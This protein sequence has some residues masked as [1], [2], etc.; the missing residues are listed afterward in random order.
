MF[1]TTGANGGGQAQQ[2][3][4]PKSAGTFYQDFFQ[5]GAQAAQGLLSGKGNPFQPVQWP[6]LAPTNNRVQGGLDT[7]AQIARQGSAQQFGNDALS[8]LYQIMGRQGLPQGSGASL[9]AMR[10]IINGNNTIGGEQAYRNIAANPLSSQ[11]QTAQQTY[12]QGARGGAD[13]GTGVYDSIVRNPSNQRMDNAGQTYQQMRQGA[14]DVDVSGYRPYVNQ[15]ANA[16]QGQAQ[17]AFGEFMG[18]QRNVSTGR[19][20]DV[21]SNAQGPSYSEQHL[22]DLASAKPGEN[23]FLADLNSL[24]NDQIRS[25]SRRAASSAGRGYGSGFESSMTADAISRNMLESALSQY[26]LDADRKISA[27]NV[28]DTQRQAGLGM[29]RALAGDIAGVQGDNQNRALSSANSVADLGNFLASQGLS[30]ANSKASVLGQNQD[31]RLGAAQAQESLGQQTLANRMA[32]ANNR[33]TTQ[34]SNRDYARS[35]ADAL[36]GLGQ[37]GTQNRLASLQGLAQVQGANIA[38][39]A[40]TAQA[41]LQARDTGIGNILQSLAMGPGAAASRYGDANQLLSSGDYMQSRQDA[42]RAE[43]VSNM[44]QQRLADVQALQAYMQLINGSG[45]SMSYQANADAISAQKPNPLAQT[46]GMVGTGLGIANQ[47]GLLGGVGN[48]LGG[49]F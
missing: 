4:A 44:E 12:Q 17:G 7:M 33:A 10:G 9:N 47:T 22:S 34:Q 39:R 6:T 13:I 46:L 42:L 8:Q 45:P 38:N 21:Y 27:S 35:S 36:A 19:M 41:D 25:E 1:T 14:G 48:L 26:N 18:G 20:E 37:Q 30:A 15:Q 49:L 2:Q 16:Q 31:R 32:A 23:P 28:M 40:N 11:Q 5:P 24:I 3:Q 43:Q 29:Q